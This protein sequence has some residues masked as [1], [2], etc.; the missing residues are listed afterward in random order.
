MRNSSVSLR[1]VA[2]AAG[3]SL[4]TASRALNNKANVLPETRALVL[5]AATNLGYRVQFRVP[6]VG[7]S[8]LNTI[9]VLLKRDPSERA[10]LDP[11]YYAVLCGIEDECERLGINLM[12]ASLRVDEYSNAVSWSSVLENDDVDG[13]MIVGAVFN[14][15]S[16]IARIPRQQPMVV[17]DAVATTLECDMVNTHNARGGYDAVSYLIKQGHTRIGLIGSTTTEPEHPSITQRRQGY[18]KALTEHGIR[19]TYIQDSQLHADNA[20]A[21]THQLLDRWPSI[22]AIFA[23]NDDIAQFVIKAVQDRGLTVPDDISVIGFDDTDVAGKTRPPLT[24][25]HVDKELMGALAVRQ[26][27]E[28]AADTD[29]LPIT[30]LMGTKLVERE[31][32]SVYVG[33]RQLKRAPLAGSR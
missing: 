13:L 10:K 19:E 21:A 6:T 5:K 1:D 28:R 3:V 4:G 29:R 20:Y 26:L 18:L 17:V 32:V 31:S 11:F 12:Y 2:Q 7:V 16:I 30:M 14:D 25:M 15:P 33:N 9:C 23:C 8:K 22:T 27:Y 24:T